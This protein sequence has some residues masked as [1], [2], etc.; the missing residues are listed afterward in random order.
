[1]TFVQLRIAVL[2]LISSM[3]VSGN[4]GKSSDDGWWEWS[5]Y[6]HL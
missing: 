1:L 4:M 5:C 3:L 2:L 6:S